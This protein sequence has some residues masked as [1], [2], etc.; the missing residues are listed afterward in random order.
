MLKLTKKRPGFRQRFFRGTDE[1]IEKRRQ[2]GWIV[3]DCKD[4]N[5]DAKIVGEEGKLDTTVRR[6]E[7]VL[8][9]LPEE[10]GL[11][12]DAY[13]KH[14]TDRQTAMK[15]A[16]ALR[17]YENLKR[18]GIDPQLTVERDTLEAE[19]RRMESRT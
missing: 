17:E 15:S 4:Y 13:I 5:L 8:M 11:Q 7:L 10:L 14:K 16:D 18:E 1:S 19:R 3:A 2:Q 9:E 6:R 12:R